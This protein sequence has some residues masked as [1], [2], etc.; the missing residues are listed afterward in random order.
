MKQGCRNVELHLS[1]AVEVSRHVGGTLGRG[2]SLDRFLASRI[3][4]SG[5]ERANKAEIT[6]DGFLD[7]ASL[8]D[9]TQRSD[10]LSLGA[11]RLGNRTRL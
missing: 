9:Q 11:E 8:L 2:V 1:T 10:G 7:I 3:G 5:I 4:S 6:V